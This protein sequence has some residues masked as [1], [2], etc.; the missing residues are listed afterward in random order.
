MPN[1]QPAPPF[2]PPAEHLSQHLFSEAA[3]AALHPNTSRPAPPGVTLGGVKELLIR[4]R[5]LHAD[6][7]VITGDDEA[8]NLASRAVRMPKE[9]DE[10]M[11][12]IPYVIPAQLFAALLADAKGIDADAPRSL[13]K[14]TRTL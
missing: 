13:S 7:L 3:F 10:F 4:L 2:S 9:I 1:V 11:A 12:A 6:T 8:A 14:V 5:E